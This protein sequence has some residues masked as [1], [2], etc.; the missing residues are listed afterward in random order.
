MEAKQLGSESNLRHV[1]KVGQTLLLRGR[2]KNNS[3]G[4]SKL[5]YQPLE[6]RTPSIKKASPFFYI[7]ILF[8]CAVL[9]LIVA[10]WNDVGLSL[11]ISSWGIY[12][13]DCFK[14]LELVSFAFFSSFSV[15]S[16]VL[17]HFYFRY[18]CLLGVPFCSSKSHGNN[19]TPL[20]DFYAREF[21]YVMWYY[22]LLF[23]ILYFVMFNIIW[24][25]K[26][27]VIKHIIY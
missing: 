24:P 11:F 5:G 13:L 16:G 2:I 18:F 6:T 25:L 14:K 22:V 4:S 10:A 21:F 9:H 17:F 20:E 7:Y 27:V 8:L 3:Q 19:H 12:K 26:I 23:S 15:A 1:I